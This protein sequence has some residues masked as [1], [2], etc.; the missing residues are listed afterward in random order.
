M[1]I[2]SDAS[3]VNYFLQKRCKIR[4]KT[5]ISMLASNSDFITISLIIN[6]YLKM[7][8]KFLYFLENKNHRAT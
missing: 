2:N 6:C 4:S 7:L 8:S 5:K 3:C 1:L